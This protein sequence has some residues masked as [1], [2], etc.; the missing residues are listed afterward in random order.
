MMKIIVF[1]ILLLFQLFSTLSQEK[2]EL[3]IFENIKNW[4]KEIIEFPIDWAPSLKV[5]GFEELLFMPSWKNPKSEQ[6]W[7]LIIGWNMKT[8]TELTLNEIEYQF[9]SYFDGLMKPNN[10][11]KEF[12]KPEVTF[13][14][15]SIPSTSILFFL[16][17]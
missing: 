2:K 17:R 1:I 16:A 12:P 15:S 5:S 14:D 4:E 11:A 8:R 9:K 13:R 7:S 10:W 3:S 6:F